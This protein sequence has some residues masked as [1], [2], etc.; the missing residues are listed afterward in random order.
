MLPKFHIRPSKMKN[1]IEYINIFFLLWIFFSNAQKSGVSIAPL[2]QD[3]MVIQQ[4]SNVPIWGWAEPN[5][6]I[7]IYSSWNDKTVSAKSN[8]SGKFTTNLETTVAGGPFQ[9]EISSANKIVLKNV[10]LGE[11]WLPAASFSSEMMG[12]E[13][14][15][16]SKR[17]IRNNE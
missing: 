2:F 11:V 4:Q 15:Q 13:G 7:N 17:Q 16:E 14:N 8:A 10:M 1:K 9:I 3:N 12:I 5:S 6:E